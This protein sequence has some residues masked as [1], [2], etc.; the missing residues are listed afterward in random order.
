MTH[1]AISHYKKFQEH[2]TLRETEEVEK[3]SE[4]ED[5][6]SEESEFEQDFEKGV[7]GQ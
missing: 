3:E 5:D 6:E 7:D 1:E 4:E 2:F